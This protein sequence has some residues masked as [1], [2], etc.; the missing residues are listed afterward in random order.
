MGILMAGKNFAD[1]V[2]EAVREKKTPLI[3]GLDPRIGS[4]PSQIVRGKMEKYGKN[5]EAAAEIIIEF[6]HVI[7]DAVHDAVAAVKPQMA[8]YEQFGEHGVHAFKDTV[9]YA[10]TRGLLVIED[11]KRNDIGSTAEAYADGHIGTVDVC[12]TEFPIFDVDAI[13]VNPYLGWD[14]VKPFAKYCDEGEKGMFVLCKTSNPSSGDFQDRFVMVSSEEG[15]L[16]EERLLGVNIGDDVLDNLD[17]SSGVPLYALVG[18]KIDEWGKKSRGENGYSS[19]GAVV[20]ATYPGQA[21]MLRS[22]I[23]H[24]LFLVPGYGAQGGTGEDI[25]NFFDENGMGAVVNSSRGVIFAY[26]TAPEKQKERWDRVYG[27]EEFGDAAR[28]AALYSTEDIVGN[29]KKAGKWFE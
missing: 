21:R 24:T 15:A 16:I 7:I 29:L 12:G 23:P 19:V 26:Q 28:A 4:I 2:C 22:L 13:T 3:A 17:F 20:G 5:P 8:F 1:R 10:R 25:P 27:P 11:A 18:M 6:N 14:G 9:D